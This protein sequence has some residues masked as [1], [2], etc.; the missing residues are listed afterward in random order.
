PQRTH[1]GPDLAPGRQDRRSRGPDE[2]ERSSHRT[3][4]GTLFE[5]GSVLAPQTERLAVLAHRQV[6]A[7]GRELIADG[8][9]GKRGHVPRARLEVQA[10]LARDGVEHDI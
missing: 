3:A 10:A 4:D 5:L 1:D 7:P 8:K 6:V 9:A 2:P